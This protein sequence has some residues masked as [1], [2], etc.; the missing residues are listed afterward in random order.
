MAK[1]IFRGRYAKQDIFLFRLID[2]IVDRKFHV[3]ND[4]K[5]RG[6]RLLDPRRLTLTQQ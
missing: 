4:P 1:K 6:C 2:D 5:Y 3:K